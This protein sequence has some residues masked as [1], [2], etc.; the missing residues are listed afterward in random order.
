M[1]NNIGVF[2]ID[3]MHAY[4]NRCIKVLLE[5]DTIFSGNCKDVCNDSDEED[6]N[7]GKSEIRY[8]EQNVEQT[9]SLSDRFSMAAVN[10][11]HNGN[12]NK[13]KQMKVKEEKKY[14]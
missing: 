11:S 2:D 7:C 12:M 8:N 4:I 5:H 1:D 3:T 14:F 6:I 10:F 13:E 9:M